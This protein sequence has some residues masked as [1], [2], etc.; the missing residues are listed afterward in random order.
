MSEADDMRDRFDPKL[1]IRAIEGSLGF[2][3]DK[4]VFGPAP[5]LRALGDIR[6]SLRDPNC[7]GPDPVYGIVMDVGRRR[8]RDEL[9]RR[10]LLFG[11][12]TYAAGQLGDS[13]V[14]SQGHVHTVAPSCGWSP[15]E[16]FEIWEGSAIVYA[17]ER[18]ADNPGRCV[19]VK[20]NPGDKVVV[21]PGW[22]HCV[23]NGSTESSMTFGAWCHRQYGF[24][25]TDIRARGGLAW[26]PVLDAEKNIRWDPNPRYQPSTLSL[27][28]ARVYA[29][30]GLEES[31]T[32]YEL[33]SKDPDALVWVADPGQR[34]ELWPKFEI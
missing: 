29:E 28:Q 11:V 20:A 21:P 24:C 6:A 18:A 1:G 19:A 10:M 12:V 34:S 17:Q 3:Y 2:R 23:V 15:P 4:D 7:Q 14:R 22:A 30:L 31:V 9:E 27:R 13:P 8:H 5:E 16:V 26:F 32:A 25:Y 33:F